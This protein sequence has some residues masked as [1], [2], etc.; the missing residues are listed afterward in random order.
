MQITEIDL[1]GSLLDLRVL[2]AASDAWAPG[3]RSSSWS[4]RSAYRRSWSGR[5]A[6]RRRMACPC[7]ACSARCAHR[8]SATAHAVQGVGLTALRTQSLEG[9]SKRYTAS[10]WRLKRTAHSNSPMLGACAMQATQSLSG[11]ACLSCSRT[12]L[13]RRA[14]ADN[15]GHLCSQPLLYP[16]S[17]AYAALTCCLPCAV[18]PHVN[19]RQQPG[20]QGLCSAR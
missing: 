20:W 18:T 14:P 19:L 17:C 6:L 12:G 8:K 5:A 7:S 1:P 10:P 15:T 13:Y 9:R 11:C 2:G 16:E 4:G 3:G